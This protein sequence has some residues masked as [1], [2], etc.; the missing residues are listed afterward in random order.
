MP[1]FYG[2]GLGLYDDI[3]QGTALALGVAAFA[4]QAVLA[5]LWL[6][7]FLYGPLEWLWRAAT[8]GTTRIAFRRPAR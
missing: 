5:R 4:L 8:R 2:F 6:G 1:I 3:G 7:R